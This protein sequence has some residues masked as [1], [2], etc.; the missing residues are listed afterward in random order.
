MKPFKC[1]DCDFKTKRKHYLNLHIEKLH[2]TGKAKDLLCPKCQRT[3]E[4][5]ASLN[6][7]MK[8][9]HKQLELGTQ[10]DDTGD[11]NSDGDAPEPVDN[12]GHQ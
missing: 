7:H 3:F 9:F 2:R 11:G 6:L 5:R 8:N 4:W 12:S 10:D 1:T